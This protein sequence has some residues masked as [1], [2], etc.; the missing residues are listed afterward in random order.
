[1]IYE[2]IL[3]VMAEKNLK[4]R[5]VY[6]PLGINRVNFYKAVKTKNLGNPTLKKILDFLEV[7][8]IFSLQKK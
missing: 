6:T 5:D 8:I 4:P 3:Q 1:M 2:Q 7:E